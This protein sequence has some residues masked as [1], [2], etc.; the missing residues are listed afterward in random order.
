MNRDLIKIES[1]GYILEEIIQNK[2]LLFYKKDSGKI[3]IKVFDI[4]YFKYIT[5]RILMNDDTFSDNELIFT[6]LNNSVKITIKSFKNIFILYI[7]N[8]Y[9][10]SLYT[11]LW[12]K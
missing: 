11:H 9:I 5:E 8:I 4:L 1:D 3:D 2:E 6:Y 12:P 7:I 10:C